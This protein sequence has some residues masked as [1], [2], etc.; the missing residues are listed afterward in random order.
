MIILEYDNNVHFKLNLEI[1]GSSCDA[2]KQ[3]EIGNENFEKLKL[4]VQR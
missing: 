3:P 2:S 1:V 4:L